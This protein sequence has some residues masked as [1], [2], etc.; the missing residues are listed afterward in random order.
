ME[1]K[2]KTLKM[3]HIAMCI[4]LV[5]VYF[6]LGE[7]DSI[8]KLLSP[9]MDATNYIY[10]S[11]PIIAYIL[12]NLLFKLQLKNI[13]LKL[14]FEEKYPFYQTASLIRWA[15]LEGAA[16]LILFLQKELIVFGILIIAYLILIRPTENRM[17]MDLDKNLI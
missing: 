11:I 10:L 16:F 6:F 1:E 5:L 15:V 13:N 12:S 4:G 8:D 2:L 14:D 17:K 3:I 7:I 9:K